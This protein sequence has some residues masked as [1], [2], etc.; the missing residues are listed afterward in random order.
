MAPPTRG[1]I[2][3][4]ATLPTFDV[5][6]YHG[7]SWVSIAAHV[8]AAS[9]IL[10]ATGGEPTGVAMGPAVQ[11]TASLTLFADSAATLQT[12][13]GYEADGKP[14]RISFGF[15]SSDKLIRF[16]GALTRYGGA[17]RERSWE[18]GGWNTHIEAQEVRSPL[19][20]RR[21][22]ATATSLTS[23]EDPDTPGYAGGLINYILWQCGGRPVEQDG[24]PTYQSEAV[25]WYSCTQALIAPEYSW[26]PG[27]NPWELIRQLCR[28]AGGQ[29]YQDGEG[30]VRY[31]DPITLATGTPA[32]TFTDE[33]L[34]AAERVSQGKAGYGE[35]SDEHDSAI[36]VTGVTCTFVSRLVQGLQ[37]VYEDTIP[38]QIA[39]SATLEIV[40]DTQLPLFSLEGA[41]VDGAVIRTA[42]QTTSADITISASLDSAQR[43]IVTVENNVAE[44]VML[45]NVRV[46]G[47]P[48]SA[49]EEGSAEYIVSGARVVTADES[50]FIQSRR[51]A[52][53]L[54]RMIYDGAN[55]AGTLYTLTDAGYDP[56][57]Y[58]GEVVGLT[59]EDRGLADERTRLVRIDN[60]GGA[61]MAAA[62]APL[63]DL[64]T[65]DSVHIIGAVS[66]VKDMAY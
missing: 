1:Q 65:L 62:L 34:T 26:I 64:P 15:D 8:N 35:C 38:R 31:V 54:C 14:V 61:F 32:F 49:G 55:G 17:G 23:A 36:A 12:L 43:V 51:H 40:C 56:D 24:N 58:V 45:D 29:V 13:M 22:I 21:P 46:R 6:V 53:M 18:C 25:F 3:A 30:V 66:G 33:Q 2:V 63:G 7:G 42:R 39:G 60:D 59:N 57:R 44:P 16:G 47:R 41:Q 48:V 20:R 5:E 19:F 10:E 27:G 11:P 37:T 50:P 52:L 4:D 28:A 9:A